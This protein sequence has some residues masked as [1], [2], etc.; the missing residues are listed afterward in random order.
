MK[1]GHIWLGSR[2]PVVWVLAPGLET[3]R[4]VSPVKGGNIQ[5]EA[6]GGSPLANA[7]HRH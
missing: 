4:F 1:T 2:R 6:A 3:S 7:G 5:K